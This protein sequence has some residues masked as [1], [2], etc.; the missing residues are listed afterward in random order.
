MSLIYEREKL[1]RELRQVLLMNRPH[2]RSLISSQSDS[3]MAGMQK[4][5]DGLLQTSSM[6]LEGAEAALSA[7]FRWLSNK[8]IRKAR[9]LPCEGQEIPPHLRQILEQCF[10][11]YDEYLR[12]NAMKDGF[13][14]D[15][16]YMSSDRKVTGTATRERN[17]TVHS[18]T[19][20]VLRTTHEQAWVSSSPSEDLREELA[21]SLGA[22]SRPDEVKRKG[23]KVRCWMPAMIVDV[24]A[25]EGGT[26]V[27]K[28]KG[29]VDSHDEPE[30][31][32]SSLGEGEVDVCDG[33]MDVG[34]YDYLFSHCPATTAF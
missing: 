6:K 17:M 13:E 2:M 20:W 33:D 16:Y 32:W 22:S 8:L 24:D 14:D 27:K 21:R 30:H 34:N 10:D 5:V 4:T 12:Q 7:G 28:E 25:V 11:K 26:V 15:L 19:E 18:G 23:E 31:V 3:E 1:L 29:I 9:G